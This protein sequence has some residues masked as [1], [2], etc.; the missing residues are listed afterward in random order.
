MVNNRN[1][2][3]AIYD[4]QSQFYSTILGDNDED[5]EDGQIR[6]TVVK[7]HKALKFKDVVRQQ[8]L[9]AKTS[10]DAVS[11][12]EDEVDFYEV[13]DWNSPLQ[14][15]FTD[16]LLLT[17]SNHVLNPFCATMTLLDQ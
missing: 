6:S 17:Y 13:D 1:Q 10:R 14:H 4:A 5:E 2:D 11:S 16:A 9:D 8:I 7:S 3:P 12:S 15:A